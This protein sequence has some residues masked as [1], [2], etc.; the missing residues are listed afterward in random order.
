MRSLP[1]IRKRSAPFTKGELKHTEGYGDLPC[2]QVVPKDFAGSSASKATAPRAAKLA[3]EVEQNRKKDRQ[4]SQAD[5]IPFRYRDS[6][7]R[8]VW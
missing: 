7:I 1:G 8:T 6:M 4:R 2:P 5:L 3:K